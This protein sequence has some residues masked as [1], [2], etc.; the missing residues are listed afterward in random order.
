MLGQQLAKAAAAEAGAVLL[1]H[2]GAHLFVCRCASPCLTPPDAAWPHR[3]L[4]SSPLLY[5]QAGAL[6]QAEAAVRKEQAE[7]IKQAERAE[8]QVGGV[9]CVFGRVALLHSLVAVGWGCVCVSR[10]SVRRS[11]QS[12]VLSQP[13]VCC[14][15]FDFGINA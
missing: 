13:A 3:I 10:H 1:P 11:G 7:V 5:L 8:K 12:D 6:K 2:A 15:V 4:F 9:S 14:P